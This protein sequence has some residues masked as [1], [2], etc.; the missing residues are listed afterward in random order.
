MHGSPHCHL[1]RN[2]LVLILQVQPEL[3]SDLR[4]YRR[5]L[6]KHREN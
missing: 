4:H 3:T 5:S 1:A 6:L 2:T